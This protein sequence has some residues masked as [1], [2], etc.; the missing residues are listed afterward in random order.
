MYQKKFMAIKQHRK[1]LVINENIRRT[2]FKKRE[3]G[4]KSPKENISNRPQ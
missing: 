1:I 3:R 4:D 2:I